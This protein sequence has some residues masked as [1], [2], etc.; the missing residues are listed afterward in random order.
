MKRVCHAL[1]TEDESVLLGALEPAS[2]DRILALFAYGNG[3][4]ALAMLQ[5][6]P[7]MICAHDFF[8][9]AGLAAQLRLKQWLFQNLDCPSLRRFLGIGGGCYRAERVAIIEAILQDLPSSDKKF[10][11]DRANSL[12][13]GMA[14]SDSTHKWTERLRF[15]LATYGR[16]PVRIQTLLLWLAMPFGSM[17]F[18]GEERRHSLGYHQMKQNPRRVLARLV[19]RS[20]R[21]LAT[22]SIFAYSELGYL[23]T[24]GHAAIRKN[25][26]RLH[27][28]DQVRR[29]VGYD[30]IYCS[31]LIDYVPSSVFHELLEA[32]FSDRSRPHT[33]F[34]NSTYES[35]VAHPTLRRGLQEKLFLI[36]WQRTNELRDRDRVRLYPGL[37]V[38]RET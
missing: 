38:L 8:D 6:V 9:Q 21:M 1:L 4:A 2:S 19:D 32:V 25:L 3:D 22:G 18:P 12:R 29:E 31:N 26:H 24:E 7:L 17:L 16:M 14:Y 20:E 11:M 33:V 36:D 23:S 35:A 10:W 5:A 30:K 13:A 34:F 27:I 28:V 37:T 15:F